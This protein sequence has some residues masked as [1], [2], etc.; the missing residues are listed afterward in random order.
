MRAVIIFEYGDNQVVRVSEIDQPV[1]Q[2][3]EVLVKVHAAGVNPVDWKIRS[4]AGQRF[5]LELPIRLGSEVAGTVESVGAGVTGL[6]LA[7]AV[8][9]I[10]PSGGFAEYVVVKAADVVPKPANIDFEQAAAIPLAALTAW[11]GVFDKAEA[12]SG[13][14]LLVTN[15]SGGVGSFAVQLAKARGVHV[16]AMASQRNEA[17]VRELGADR[18]VDYTAEPFEEV[19]HDMDAVFDTVGGETYERAFLTLKRGGV[20]VTTVSF[21]KN[22]RRTDEIRAMRVQCKP[23]AVQLNSIRA[24][25]EAGTVR[26]HVST[27]LPLDRVTDAL[28]LSEQ[29]HTRGKIVLQMVA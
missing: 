28:A 25:V 13:Q 11:Q 1:P 15:S 14:R 29:G 9:G 17:Y 6:R 19:V 18:F 8:Y 2:A 23:S 26:A 24:L 12:G 27:L 4:G 3:G 20:L 16:T 5:G 10:V 7:E 22:E 21:P